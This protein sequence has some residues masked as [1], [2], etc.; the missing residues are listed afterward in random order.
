[1]NVFVH[2]RHFFWLFLAVFMF[3]WFGLVVLPWMELGHLAPI[4]SEGS[5]DITPWDTTGAAHQ[6]ER[7]YAANGCAYCHTQQV[8]PLSSGADITRGWGSAKDADGKDVTRRSYPR[9]YIWQGQT[10]LGNSRDGAD[11][12]NVAQR[13]PDA[14]GLYRYLYDPYI[15]NPHSSMPAFKFLF[16]TRK[17]SG[18]PSEDAL[19]LT[20]TD[21]PPAG[22][23]VVPTAQARSLVA[24]LLSLKKGYHLAP[25]EA[26]IP[27]M[28]P[29]PDKS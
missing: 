8:R 29:T 27:Y 4:E 12:S 3:S 2:F 9:D 28:P 21:A 1:M 10:F 6:G 13:F 15:L 5:T 22:Y 7:I 16:V 24:Y 17:V 20:D 18:Q 11:L 23:E 25:D 14:A 19:V 26:G